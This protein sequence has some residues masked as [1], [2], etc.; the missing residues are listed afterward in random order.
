MMM[1]SRLMSLRSGLRCEWMP[2]GQV[3]PVVEKQMGPEVIR[4]LCFL[5]GILTVG[6]E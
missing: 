6:L 5:E 2:A 1:T 4:G 3:L